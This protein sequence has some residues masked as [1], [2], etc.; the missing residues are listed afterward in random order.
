MPT[1]PTQRASCQSA[2]ARQTQIPV[3]RPTYQQALSDP[4]SLISQQQCRAYYIP[5]GSSL[6]EGGSWGRLRAE[7]T[8]RLLQRWAAAPHATARVVLLEQAEPVPGLAAFL[9]GQNLPL[10]SWELTKSTY[11]S[12]SDDAYVGP[13]GATPTARC[14]GGTFSITFA[15]KIDDQQA[16]AGG[17]WLSCWAAT[18]PVQCSQQDARPVW[19]PRQCLCPQV[20]RAP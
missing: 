13:A 2:A 15:H 11:G 20:H 7:V 8:A 17:V 16:R 14:S 6:L 18:C 4:A 12:T 1:R 9:G 5:N 10:S 3:G 19:C